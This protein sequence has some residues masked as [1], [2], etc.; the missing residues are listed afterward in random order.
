MLSI[1]LASD[2]PLII[3]LSWKSVFC[4]A[5]AIP[6][7]FQ[8]RRSRAREEMEMHERERRG[9]RLAG[10]SGENETGAGEGLMKGMEEI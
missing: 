1:S 8:T 6:Y 7:Y 2:N 5:G 10:L 4:T 3:R 9:S